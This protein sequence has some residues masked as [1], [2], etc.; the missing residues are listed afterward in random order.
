MYLT[1]LGCHGPYP[2]PEGA[3]SGYLLESDSGK[4]RLILDLGGGCL[5]RLLA[6]ARPE[7]LS[8]VVLTHL[9]YDHMSDMLPLQYALQFSARP[10]PLPVYL[11]E[12]PRHVRQLLQCPYFD[13]FAHQDGRVGEMEISYLPAAH[14]V[15]GSSVR[16]ECD[17]AALVF[18]GDTNLNPTLELFCD[19]CDLLLADANMPLSEW[20]ERK[21]HLSAAHC[22]R[23][24]RD[25]KVR[26]LYLTHANPAF[27]AQ[28]LLDEA[29]DAFAGAQAAVAGL[30][31]R[32]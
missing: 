14:T 28:A 6:C 18:T 4:T 1:V 9:H 11:P 13:L 17:G 12:E 15:P 23:I 26:A 3:C 16:I 21:P 22:G 32:V 10:R 29:R 2:A 31:V 27:D 24:A 8:A 30:R 25:A 5:G 19:G 20:S 7:D